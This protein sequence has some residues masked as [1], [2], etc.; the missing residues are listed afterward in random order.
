MVTIKEGNNSGK[1]IQTPI[2]DDNVPVIM[3]KDQYEHTGTCYPSP[4]Q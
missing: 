4:Q 2:F 1:N 3:S